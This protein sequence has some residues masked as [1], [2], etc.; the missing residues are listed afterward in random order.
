LECGTAAEKFTPRSVHLF[1]QN[2]EQQ[3][4]RLRNMARQ[5]QH[6]VVLVGKTLSEFAGAET[7][8]SFSH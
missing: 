2:P 7:L 4:A 6:R 3:R 1:A 8:Q 5:P